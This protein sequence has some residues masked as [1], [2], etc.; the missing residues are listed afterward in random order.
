LTRLFLRGR[1]LYQPLITALAD[2]LAVVHDEPAVRR[3]LE[4]VTGTLFPDCTV[5][6][7]E[8]EPR[9]PSAGVWWV[10][11]P[12]RELR[13]PLT[14]AGGA[15]G[16]LAISAR[17]T[18]ALFTVDELAILETLSSFGAVALHNAN[19]LRQLNE[20]RELEVSASKEDKRLSVDLLAAEVAHEIA[21]P[22][23]YFRHFLR[24][25]ARGG[26]PI[27]EDV[28]LGQEEV[29]RLERML[30]SVRRLQN[31]SPV[32]RVVD[33]GQVVDRA[34]ALLAVDLR[35]REQQVARVLE[36]DRLTADADQLLQVFSNL[37]R[38]GSEAAGR[39]GRLGIS[40]VA[41]ADHTEV[42]VWDDGP[43]I[44]EDARAKVFSPWFTTRPEGTGLGLA[45][46]QRIIQSFGWTIEIERRGSLT[47]FVLRAPLTPH[48]T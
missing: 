5:R 13:V 7:V 3:A 31:P 15:L 20:L 42:C 25:L 11:G 12:P 47:T 19:T 30:A 22:L 29:S 41:R 16:A 38:N 45:V 8:L 23:N 14:T 10:D 24:G 2:R 21:Y 28:E 46:T 1:A 33:L 35:A 34:I 37:L 18:G 48:H 32:L 39:G 27:A 4:E 6:F 26:P 44:A 9:D 36:V 43:G 17:P 40:A